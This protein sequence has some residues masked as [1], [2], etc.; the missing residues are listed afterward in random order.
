PPSPSPNS[1]GRAASNCARRFL[2]PSSI[3]RPAAPPTPTPCS[4]RPFEGFSPTPEMPEIAE[5]QPLLAA[6]A[7][8]DEVRARPTGGSGERTC[9]ALTAT[10]YCRLDGLLK[11]AL[12]EAEAR[13]GDV[14]RALAILDEALATCER[15]GQRAFEAELHR[16]RGEMLLR[17]DPA[18]PALT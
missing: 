4:R 18:N 2:W 7:E 1:K 16:V 13:G 12:A 9:T 10:R 5:A 8:A 11:I 17:R 3:S 6:L 14:V 15:I